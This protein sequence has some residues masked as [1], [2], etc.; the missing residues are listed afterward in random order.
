MF[1]KAYLHL[2]RMSRHKFWNHS[3]VYEMF[4]LDFMLDDN[5][6]LWLIEVNASPQL[7]GTNPTKEKLMVETLSDLFEIQYAY[8]RSK[9]KRLYAIVH[10]VQG[11]L[12]SRKP[13]DLEAAKEE[14]A[15]ANRNYL[16][17]EWQ[18]RSNVS[19]HKILDENIPGKAA[20]MGIL[21]DECILD[22]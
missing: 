20:Y 19:W 9:M 14:F 3:S 5:L 22:R 16:E 1:K 12:Y 6:G 2:V 7:I 18:I 15:L 17:P 13:F 4:G 10:K 11:N 21:E 8:L